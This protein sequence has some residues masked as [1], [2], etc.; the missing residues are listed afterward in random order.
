M[1]GSFSI[2]PSC[3]CAS[4]AFKTKIWYR[5]P[6]KDLKVPPTHYFILS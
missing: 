6:R 2:F 3:L 1:A 4:T 5:T